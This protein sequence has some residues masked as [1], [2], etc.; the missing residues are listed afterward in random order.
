MDEKIIRGLYDYLEDLG[1]V[2]YVDWIKDPK[3]DRSKVNK[4]TAAKL[5]IEMHNSKCLFYAHSENSP[6]SKWMPWELGYFDGIRPS[7][8]AI[9]PIL[10]EEGYNFDRQ[11]YLSLYPYVDDTNGKLYIHEAVGL[12]VT[13]DEWLK[14]K[15]PAKH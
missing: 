10:P 12:W 15:E 1:Y 5:K 3:L 8:V 4:W 2:V 7:K 6:N 11:E 9:L 14:G 13:F